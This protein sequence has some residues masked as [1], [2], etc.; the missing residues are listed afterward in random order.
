MRSAYLLTGITM[1]LCKKDG[2]AICI[3]VCLPDSFEAFTS[4]VKP[5]E[6]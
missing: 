3:S 4:T 6:W 5:F 2:L 1:R